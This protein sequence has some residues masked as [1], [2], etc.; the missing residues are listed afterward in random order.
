MPVQLPRYGPD[1]AHA[2][3]TASSCFVIIKFAGGYFEKFS[4]AIMREMMLWTMAQIR[5]IC[6]CGM[7]ACIFKINQYGGFLFNNRADLR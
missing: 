7:A 5:G 3:E 1:A 4:V 2:S 6:H